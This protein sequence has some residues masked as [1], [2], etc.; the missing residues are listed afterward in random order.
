MSEKISQQSHNEAITVAKSIQKPGQS[1]EHTKLIAAGIEK[2]IATYK[3]QHKAKMRAQDKQRKKSQRIHEK[4]IDIIN[5]DTLE[6]QNIIL[7]SPHAKLPWILLILSWLGF[8]A[9][10]TLFVL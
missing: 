5:N 3:K 2:G 9:Y 7:S 4:S 6:P 10:I 8:I 1:K